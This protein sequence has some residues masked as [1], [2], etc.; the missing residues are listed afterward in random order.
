MSRR[1]LP[2]EK[3]ARGTSRPYR[4]AGVSE[5]VETD[6][7]P[8]R[9]DSLTAAGEA[10][11][12]DNVGRVAAGRLVGERDSAMFGQWCNLIAALDQCWRAGEVPPCAHLTEARRLAEAFGLL[13]ARS[14]LSARAA[15]ADSNPFLRNGLQAR[16]VRS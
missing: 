5:L 12:L 10:I 2:S 4:D 1:L 11:W 14:R 8:Q 15:R 7:L 13:G 3:L 9:P 6:S 16:V